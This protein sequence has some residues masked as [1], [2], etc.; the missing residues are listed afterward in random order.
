MLMQ[1]SRKYDSG[2]AH[3]CTLNGTPQISTVP[4]TRRTYFRLSGCSKDGK[5]GTYERSRTLWK[6]LDDILYA[7]ATCTC[8]HIAQYSQPQHQCYDKAH[9]RGS[10]PPHPWLTLSYSFSLD[11]NAHHVY[12]YTLVFAEGLPRA[13]GLVA[14]RTIHQIR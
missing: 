11:T 5:N 3:L 7:I 12:P 4:P 8:A 2:L 10:L 1:R 9:A 6:K 13:V 14:S